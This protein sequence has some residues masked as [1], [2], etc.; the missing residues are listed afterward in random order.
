M[1]RPADPE[2]EGVAFVGGID[3]A[4]SRRDDASH[5]GDPQPQPIAAVYGKRP[6]WHDVQAQVRGPAVADLEHTFRE[7]WD[8]PT[9]LDSRNPYRMVTDLRHGV[10]VHPAEPMPASA[11]PAGRRS[12]RRAGPA[13]LRLPARLNPLGAGA[14]P[15]A[16]RGERSI[17]RGYVKVWRRARRLIYVEDQYLWSADVAQLL[18][19]GA[20]R[21]TR[22]AHRRGRPALPRPGRPLLAGP[23]PRRT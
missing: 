11:R 13:H 12:A 17:A 22:P 10:H 16:P 2:R 20:A 23:E 8:D 15:F 21:R 14:Y 1:L 19:A 7:R 3:L 6:P 9:P 18:A 5:A 4:H